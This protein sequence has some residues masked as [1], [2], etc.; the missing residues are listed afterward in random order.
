MWAMVTA[1]V[2]LFMELLGGKEGPSNSDQLCN[3]TWRKWEG[4]RV[5]I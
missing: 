1:Q 5:F 4:T 3:I 2:L